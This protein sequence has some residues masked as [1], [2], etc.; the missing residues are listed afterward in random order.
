MSKTM[1]YNLK[2]AATMLVKRWELLDSQK[3]N[4]YKN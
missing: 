1:K 2:D 3:F 4:F